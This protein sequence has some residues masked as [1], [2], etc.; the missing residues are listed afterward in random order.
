[1][2]DFIDHKLF[3]LGNVNVWS[4]SQYIPLH[5]QNNNEEKSAIIRYIDT[6]PNL[7]MK[8]LDLWKCE[9]EKI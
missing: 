7:Y 6:D 2:C 3:Q 5:L 9:N 8:V 1:M 4:I